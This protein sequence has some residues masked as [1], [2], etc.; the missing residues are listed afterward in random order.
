MPHP[1]PPPAPHP[2]PSLP[3]RGRGGASKAGDNVAAVRKR[4]GGNGSSRSSSSSSNSRKKVTKVTLQ[5]P[6]DRRRQNAKGVRSAAQPAASEFIHNLQQQIYFLEMETQYLRSQQDG[7]VAPPQATVDDQIRALNRSFREVEQKYRA[8][9]EESS[10]MLVRIQAELAKRNRAYEQLKQYSQEAQATLEAAKARQ[11]AELQTSLEARITESKRA[12][13]AEDALAVAEAEMERQ[14]NTIK[15]AEEARRENQVRVDSELDD[16]D[17]KIALLELE[18]QKC[19]DAAGVISSEKARLESRTEEMNAEMEDL[20]ARLEEAVGLRDEAIAQ[21]KVAEANLRTAEA[22]H[23]QRLDEMAALA[24]SNT[25]L[26]TQLDLRGKELD[27]ATHRL[28]RVEEALAESNAER[29]TLRQ[30]LGAAEVGTEQLTKRVQLQHNQRVEL[31]VEL[32]AARGEIEQLKERQVASDAEAGKASDRLESSNAENTEL[33]AR[34]ER[35]AA[36]VQALT[37][38]R[39]ELSRN[40]E[41]LQSEKAELQTHLKSA[42]AQLES[43][44]KIEDLD[45]DRFRSLMQSNLEVAATLDNFMKSYRG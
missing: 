10:K 37:E 44:K 24:S 13:R 23:T 7:S 6:A 21:R 4:V 30:K 1:S 18:L 22:A 28:N 19:Q 32:A 40:V 43:S 42:E 12:K 3:R 5:P 15:D 36:D 39:D 16:R 33:L 34:C 29:G 27:Q 45:V 35:L 31:S 25:Q 2:R 26:E 14:R 8:E 17:K 41:I 20:K 38:D 11:A 9:S